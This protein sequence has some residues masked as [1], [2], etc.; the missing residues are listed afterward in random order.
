[1]QELHTRRAVPW[2]I[3][4]AMGGFQKSLMVD[5]GWISKRKVSKK[6]LDFVVFLK[7][8]EI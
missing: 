7:I 4:N 2:C 1:M 8:C 6:T 5:S 3:C